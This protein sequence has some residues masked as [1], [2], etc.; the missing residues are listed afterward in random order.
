MNK[1]E[2]SSSLAYRAVADTDAA[3]LY[4]EAFSDRET[5]LHLQW[6]THIAQKETEE[7]I[8]EM[9][10]LHRN[11]DK[12]FWIGVDRKRNKPVGLGS[13]RPDENAAW[14]GILVLK[15]EKRKGF[16][17]KMLSDLESLVHQYFASALA[18]IHEENIESSALF[19]SAG[20]CRDSSLKKPLFEIYRKIRSERSDVGNEH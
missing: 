19:E 17:R 15:N 4:S 12:F 7:L 18:E 11:G 14:I 1:P 2:D 16:G 6:D 20:W 9:L 13:I 10:E 5:T 3:V 8:V